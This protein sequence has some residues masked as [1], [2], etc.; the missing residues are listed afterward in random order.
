MYCVFWTFSSMLCKQVL[1]M[2]VCADDVVHFSSFNCTWSWTTGCPS[3]IRRL[4]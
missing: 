1:Y 4:S 3:K 2:R